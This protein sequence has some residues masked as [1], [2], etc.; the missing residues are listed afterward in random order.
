MNESAEDRPGKA[1]I[2]KQLAKILESTTFRNSTSQAKVLEYVVSYSLADEEISH[3][4]LV[5]LLFPKGH[6]DAKRTTVG[7]V[8][9]FNLRKTLS[10]YYASYGNEDPLIIEVPRGRSYRPNW[11]YNPRWPAHKLYRQGLIHMNA[12]LSQANVTSSLAYLSDAIGLEPMYAEAHAA[13]AE[14]QF[15]EALYRCDEMS[16]S[17]PWVEM[18]ESSARIAIE[19]NDESWRA[20]IV[21]GAIHS[22]RFEWS[23]AKTAFNVALRIAPLETQEHFFYSAFLAATGNLEEASG[24]MESRARRHPED[25][26]A[27]LAS[28]IVRY[29]GG[30]Q[31]LKKAGAGYGD[32]RLINEYGWFPQ[33]RALSTCLDLTTAIA[34]NGH[35]ASRIKD[36]WFGEECFPGLHIAALA[37]EWEVRNDKGVWKEILEKV[38]VLESQAA[39]RHYAPIQL[40]LALVHLAVDRL[41]DAIDDLERAFDEGDPKMAWLH[42]WPFFSRLR[43]HQKFKALI[44]RLNLPDGSRAW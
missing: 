28:S 7:R 4:H 43:G 39:S 26:F 18:A 23:E 14:V 9:T 21:L 41:D 44:Q 36:E 5:T 8:T 13:L 40:Q 16:G 27:H 2:K 33:I 24:L 20:F 31:Y 34:E 11:Y 22:A 1:E 19:A 42:L 32:I 38:E 6:V 17:L 35:C 30:P 37:R 3:Q 12:F 25:R 29:L 15:R 10:K